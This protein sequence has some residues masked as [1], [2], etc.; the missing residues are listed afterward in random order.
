MSHEATFSARFEREFVAFKRQICSFDQNNEERRRCEMC[1]FVTSRSQLRLVRPANV[2]TA[3]SQSERFA[4]R[5]IFVRK[6]K[7]ER[8]GRGKTAD[9]ALR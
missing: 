9:D 5:R 3:D 4:D 2:A 1:H 8:K 7:K 6:A